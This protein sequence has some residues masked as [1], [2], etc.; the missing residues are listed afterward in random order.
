MIIFFS[1][2][3]GVLKKTNPG[4]GK[5]TYFYIWPHSS[6]MYCIECIRLINTENLPCSTTGLQCL[7]LSKIVTVR[8]CISVDLI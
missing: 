6:Y 1:D 3:A 7:C 4:D 2:W 5:P 8:T